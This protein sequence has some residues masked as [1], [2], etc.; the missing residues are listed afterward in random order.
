[1]AASRKGPG[2]PPR[3]PRHLITRAEM[4]RR[5]GVTRAAVT[6]QCRPGGRLAPACEGVA[7]NVLHE[8]AKKWVAERDGRG[9]APSD[10]SEPIAVDDGPDPIDGD[11]PPAGDSTGTG[12]VANDVLAAE[13]DSLEQPLAELTER[14]GAAPAFNSWV[15]CRNTLATA[16]KSE[17]LLAR[18]DGRLIARTTVQNMVSHIDTA[19]RLLLTDAPR[20]IAIKLGADDLPT[21]TAMIRDVMSQALD[22]CRDH[23]AASLEADDPMAPLV[24]AAE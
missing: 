13:L 11:E 14:Y 17:R 12:G 7:V 5:L 9:R 15:K 6:R 23:M 21:A 4:A 2:A 24:E 20:T 3:E 19:F 18:L 22:A 8:A 10:E 16:R 1:M